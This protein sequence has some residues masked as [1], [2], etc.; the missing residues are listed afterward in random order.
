MSTDLL[1]YFITAPYTMKKNQSILLFIIWQFT[2][3]VITV[4]RHPTVPC[5]EEAIV[6]LKHCYISFLLYLMT[7]SRVI[8]LQAREQYLYLH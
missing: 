8:N 4:L 5:F 2:I 6:L 3:S 7:T 1:L